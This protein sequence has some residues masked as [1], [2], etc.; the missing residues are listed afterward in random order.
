MRQIQ[1]RTS[2]YGLIDPRMF[3]LTPGVFR[4]L[5]QTG[6]QPAASTDSTKSIR[7]WASFAIFGPN[8]TGTMEIFYTQNIDGR[9]CRLDETE[10]AHCIKVLRHRRGDRISVIDGK[11]NMMECRLVTDSPRGA[12]AEILETVPDWGGHPYRLHL[13]VCP[14]KNID[15]YEWFVEKAAEIGVDRITPLICDFSERK[16]IK[17]ERLRKI[18]VSA[19]KQSLQPQLVR[20]DEATGFKDFIKECA[21]SKATKLIA[22]CH[23]GEKKHIGKAMSGSK[24][25][26]VMIGPEGDF[27]EEEVTLACQNGFM[28]VTLG[29]ARL[30]V[31]TAALY[32]CFAASFSD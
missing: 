1:S 22:H 10:S 20:I 23:E 19:M 2:E 12:E 26:I 17:T 7:M 9:L 14:T 13:A 8:I 18:L 6:K 24:N 28:P 30:R 11:G 4:V 25:F 32:C 27:S 16:V 3:C 15:R 29:Q 31:E 21:C 5:P